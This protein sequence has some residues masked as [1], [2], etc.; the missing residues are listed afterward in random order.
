M[1]YLAR[2]L[3]LA[4]AHGLANRVIELSLLEAQAC[5]AEGDHQRARLALERAL[6][7]ALAAAAPAGYVRAFDQGPA[8]T[9]LLVEA[10][11][12]GVYREQLERILAAIGVPKTDWGQADPAVRSV[13]V[14]GGERLSERELEVLR[15]MA[16]G[17][18]NGEIAER[19]VITVGTVK[20]HINH[21]LGKLDS[22]NRTEAVARARRFGLLEP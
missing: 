10:A 12:S 14:P 5:R 22:H 15:L 7:R 21:V 2:Q 19:L 4:R 18:T 13:Q 9:Q 8:L 6:E 1:P 3:D 20:S 11:Q 16:Q 17:A